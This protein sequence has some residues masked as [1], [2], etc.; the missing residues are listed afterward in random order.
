MRH[1]QAHFVGSHKGEQLGSGAVQVVRQTAGRQTVWH[2]GQP[3]SPSPAIS[4]ISLG[5]L[6]AKPNKGSLCFCDKGNARLEG[7]TS[8]S[9]VG[10]R[11]DAAHRLFA[12]HFTFSTFTLRE[13]RTFITAWLLFLSF[14]KI[15]FYQHS[16][17]RTRFLARTGLQSIW[18]FG[19][20]HTGWH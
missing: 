6:Q 2:F 4:H 10:L 19:L 1:F 7:V 8:I 13:N 17:Y 9:F 16:T 15:Y 5:H 3:A 14:G 18:Q 20:A 12:V 11:P